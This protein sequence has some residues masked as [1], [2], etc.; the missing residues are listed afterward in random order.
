MQFPLLHLPLLF[1]ARR[2]TPVRT[3]GK[4]PAFRTEEVHKVLA[5]VDTS[6]VVGDWDKAFLAMLA[7]TFARVGAAVN[8][9]VEVLQLC[10]ELRDRLDECFSWPLKANGFFDSLMANW[11]Q[12]S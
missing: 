10:K 11:P 6:H 5:S 7:Y 9:K 2:K 12:A 1:V 4:T 3:E 8:L